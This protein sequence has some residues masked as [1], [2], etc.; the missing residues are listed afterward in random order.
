[1]WDELAG[2]GAREDV[3]SVARA[4]GA[5][6][7]SRRREGRPLRLATVFPFS[8]HTYQLRAFARRGG[9]ELAEAAEVVVVPPPQMVAAL[10]SGDID[11]FCV[12]SPWN[13]IAVEAGLG[14]IAALGVDIVPDAPEKVLA[15]PA[16]FAASPAVAPLLRALR[17]AGRWCADPSNRAEL[18]ALLGQ[19]RHLDLDGELI[20]RSL[21]GRLLVSPDGRERWEERYLVL[22]EDAHRPRP[23]HARWLV[24]EMVGMGQAIDGEGLD[25]AVAVYR[26]DLFV[27]AVGAV[28]A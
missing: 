16:L 19:K 18:S 10:R 23:E 28:G 3:G 24:G 27:A 2:L 1:L 15:L 7:A 9:V 8:T 13:S 6:A 25:A 14:R 11:G 5:V 17:Q 21:D 4:F 12:G 26:P 22:G 20:R